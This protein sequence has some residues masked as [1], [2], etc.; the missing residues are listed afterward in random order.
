MEYK[1]PFR[2][3]KLENILV[4]SKTNKVKIIDFGFCCQ[5]KE[6][7][8]VF[9]GTPSYMSPEIVSKK[10]YFGPPS[11][12][13]ATGILIYSLLCGSFPFKSPFEKELYRKIQKGQFTYPNYVSE[14][15]REIINSILIVD[16]SRRPTAEQILK[17]SWF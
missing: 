15:A 10:D 2:D 5:S 11:D 14:E 7:L 4:E 12:I 8:R 16:P 13:W 3:I 9:C 1:F 6:K 17:H